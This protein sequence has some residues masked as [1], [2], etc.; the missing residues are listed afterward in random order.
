MLLDEFIALRQDN[1]AR[2]R[3]LDL[4]PAHFELQGTHPALGT[5]TMRQ[6]LSAWT[7]HD[8][9][10]LLQISRVMAKRY[11]QEVGPWAEFLS[12]MK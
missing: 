8:L 12:V 2:L 7:A 6:L 1:L 4:Q 11:K 9:A 3:K 10:H 5:V